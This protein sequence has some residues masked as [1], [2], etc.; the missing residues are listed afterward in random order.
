MCIVREDNRGIAI[1]KN[2][3]NFVFFK[4][5]MLKYLKNA[6]YTHKIEKYFPVLSTR[7]C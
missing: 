5:K 6:A 1:I 7:V 2:E 4:V 3:F